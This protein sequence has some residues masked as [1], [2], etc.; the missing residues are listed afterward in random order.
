VGILDRLRGNR[1]RLDPHGSYVRTD[2]DLLV[3]GPVGGWVSDQA[4]PAGPWGGGGTFGDWPGPIGAPQVGSFLAGP[5][6][7]IGNDDFS[8]SGPWAGYPGWYENPDGSAAKGGAGWVPAITRATNVIVNAV[9]QTR[10]VMKV[11]DEDE[12]ELPAWIVDPQLQGRFPGFLTSTVPVAQRM[13]GKE[14][15][16]TVLTHA[17]WW[18]RGA[19]LYVEAY[20]GQ[21]LPGTLRIVNPFMIHRTPEGTWRI[22]GEFDT[23]FDGRFSLG[24]RTW[25]LAVMNGLPPHDG[26]TPSG[27]LI[28]HFDTFKLGATIQSWAKNS[29]ESGVPSGFLKVSTPNFSEDKATELKKSWMDAHGQGRRSVAVLNSTVDYTPIA[30]SPVDA[31]LDRSF[32]VNLMSVAHAFGLSGRMV[33]EI[34]SS[35]NYANLNDARRDLVDLSAAAWGQGLLDLLSNIAAYGTTIRVNWQ[36]FTAPDITTQVEPLVKAVEAGLLTIE[37]ARHLMGYL[38]KQLPPTPEPKAAPL[39]IVPNNNVND[40]QAAGGAQ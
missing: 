25:R 15:W 37:E 23:D 5:T 21:P 40:P 29:Y 9:I 12:P 26:F 7:W 35:L 1:A 6:W 19:F 20:D 27:V 34:G 32:R 18:G 33:D 24:G 38:G 4:Y 13:T 10:W 11:G 30:L 8:A 16:S 17:I 36:T 3:N 22:A 2:G 31:A 39:A 14:F 28:R